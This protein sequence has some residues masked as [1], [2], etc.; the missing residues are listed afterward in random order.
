MK[1]FIFKNI[2]IYLGEDRK[3]NWSLLETSRPDDVFVHF[4]TLINFL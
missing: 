3:E 1:Q 4:V 2:N